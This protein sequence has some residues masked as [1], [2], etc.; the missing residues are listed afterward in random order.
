M[1][2]VQKLVDLLDLS[3]QESITT[4]LGALSFVVSQA[5]VIHRELRGK[6]INATKG[7]VLLVEIARAIV[8]R[9]QRSGLISL[10]RLQNFSNLPS[11]R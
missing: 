7:A 6:K 2:S 1:T 10:V 4:P 3:G 5:W 9:L 8:I 11:F